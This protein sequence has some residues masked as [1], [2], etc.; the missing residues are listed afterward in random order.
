MYGDICVFFCCFGTQPHLSVPSPNRSRLFFLNVAYKSATLFVV[1]GEIDRHQ[2]AS[3]TSSTPF[4]LL[5]K[6]FVETL[7]AKNE[8]AI[9]SNS[10]VP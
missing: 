10:S 8:N 7:K 3:A 1:V 2:Q 4:L 6:H 5:L 9:F